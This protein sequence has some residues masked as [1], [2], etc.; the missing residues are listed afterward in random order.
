MVVE[1][2]LR[3]TNHDY[4]AHARQNGLK[5]DSENK[6]QSCD[7]KYSIHDTYVPH[8]NLKLAPRFKSK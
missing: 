3:Y 6:L 2:F 8:S 7:M 4:L 1:F 5:M